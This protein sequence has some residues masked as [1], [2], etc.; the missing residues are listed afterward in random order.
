MKTL[1]IELRKEKRTGVVPVLLVVGLLGAVYAFVNFLVR[2]ETLLGLPLSPMDV[3]LTQLYGMLMILNLF[4]I[5]VATCLVYNMEF[6]GNA[7]KKMYTLPTS[8]P[9]M[10]GAKFLILTA[11][12][13]VAVALENLALFKIG[14]SKIFQLAHSNPIRSFHLQRIRSS[15]RCPCC[16]SCCSSRH[17]LKTCGYRLAWASP[18]F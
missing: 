7:I 2:K 14:M 5:V 16:R 13:L 9:G 10:Y 17:G 8:V 3:L 11:A 6:K 4:G 12:F 18:A 15:R 1:R